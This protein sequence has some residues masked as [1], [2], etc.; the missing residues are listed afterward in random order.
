[1]RI[2][3]AVS[4]L[5]VI[6]LGCNSDSDSGP[7]DENGSAD[8]CGVSGSVQTTVFD[9]SSTFTDV[10]STPLRV[11]PSQQIF[12]EDLGST[13]VEVGNSGF[14]S[15]TGSLRWAGE[16]HLDT[17]TGLKS[18]VSHGAE[19]DYEL[20][21]G[22]LTGLVFVPVEPVDAQGTISA[23][24]FTY[25]FLGGG[26]QLTKYAFGFLYDYTGTSIAPP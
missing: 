9:G 17:V 13:F 18:G 19:F 4:I 11:D 2:F 6:L 26:R 1:M 10:P 16:L 8:N 14:W 7:Q 20:V 24:L 25:Y 12:E 5:S 23:T 21:T 3:L 15:I 22:D